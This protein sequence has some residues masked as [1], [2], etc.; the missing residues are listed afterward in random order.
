MSEKV[1]LENYFL[2]PNC[3]IYDSFEK[4][5]EGTFKCK[6]C[7]QVYTKQELVKQ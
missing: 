1:K 5:P 2:C 7:Y 3:S 6:N 4:Q